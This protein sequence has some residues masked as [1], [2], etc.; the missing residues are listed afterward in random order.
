MVPQ[1][2]GS[3]SKSIQKKTRGVSLE[4]VWYSKYNITMLLPLSELSDIVN[5]FRLVQLRTSGHNTV[6]LLMSI[7]I[8]SS[9]VSFPACSDNTPFRKFSER[10]SWVRFCSPDRACKCDVKM[11]KRK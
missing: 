9:F 7:F 6:M 11:K 5:I 3:L 1:L 2:W 8:V 4:S 10:F